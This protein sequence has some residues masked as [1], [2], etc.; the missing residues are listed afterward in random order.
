[1]AALLATLAGLA[2]APL[3]L[4][5]RRGLALSSP[6]REVVLG[7]AMG[8]AFFVTTGFVVWVASRSSGR[9]TMQVAFG[10]Y[11]VK[12][13]ALIALALLVPVSE[14]FDRR[15]FAV[16]TVSAAVAFLA[17]EILVVTVSSAD[18]NWFPAPTGRAPLTP[19]RSEA[20][21]PRERSTQRSSDHRG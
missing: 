15:A 4:L 19:G 2:S 21:E 14:D 11:A 9:R 5:G 16:A 1:M 18:P 17:T 12:I 3:V 8:T 13:A 10:I 6:L 20:V 7:S